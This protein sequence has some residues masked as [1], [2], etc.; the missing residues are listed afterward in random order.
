MFL[1]PAQHRGFGLFL[2]YSLHEQQYKFHLK[3]Q[4]THEGTLGADPRGNLTRME[5]A[6][7][8][9]PQ[10]LEA[11]KSRLENMYRQQASAK[12]ESVK[13]FPYEKEFREK[14]ARLTELDAILN[15]DRKES[16]RE[17]TVVTKS[18]RP[19]VLDGLKRPV[20]PRDPDRKSKQHEEVR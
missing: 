10:R 9:C 6:L 7:G 13:P 3:G 16:S 5:N 14:S 1:L 20:P 11:A 17:E 4:M 18:A 15:M 2:S 8:Q 19:S 12:E